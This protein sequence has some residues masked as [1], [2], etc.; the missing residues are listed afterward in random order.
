MLTIQKDHPAFQLHYKGKPSNTAL[1]VF[2]HIWA[3]DHAVF[4]AQ[5]RDLPTVSRAINVDLRD[6]NVNDVSRENCAI[7]RYAAG[8]A[9][10]CSVLGLHKMI[11][12]GNNRDSNISLEAAAR[13]P[14]L[15]TRSQG[16]TLSSSRHRFSLMDWYYCL[17]R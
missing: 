17:P 10:Q 3:C 2:V 8:V 15:L 16:P 7:T 5:I 11:L 6:D 1:M 13:N 4:E 9:W 14:E 12:V